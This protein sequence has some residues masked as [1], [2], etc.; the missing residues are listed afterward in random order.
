MLEFLVTAT[1][2]AAFIFAFLF[3]RERQRKKKLYNNLEEMLDA[4]M[5]GHFSESHFDESRFSKV[6]TMF[7][8]YLESSE[9]SAKAAAGER[10]RIKTLIA[11]IS[12]QTKTPICCYTVNFWKSRA[13]RRISGMIQKLF[14]PKRR[15]LSFS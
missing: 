10:D 12:H 2:A 1:A 11:D 6:E 14:M 5:E 7:A 4:A 3:F 9:T 15:S 13:L 8:D